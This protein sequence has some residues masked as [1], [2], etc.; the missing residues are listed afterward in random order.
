[1]SQK[2]KP[3]TEL[4]TE[5]AIRKLFPKPVIDGVKRDIEREANTDTTGPGAPVR[6]RKP[7]TT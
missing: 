1:M 2:P 5:Q 7:T 3:D 4:T 6:D